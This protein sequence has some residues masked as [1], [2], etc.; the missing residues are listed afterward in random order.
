MDWR[1][2]LRHLAAG[3]NK[4]ETQVWQCKLN[5]S[6]MARE[7]PDLQRAK[8]GEGTVQKTI[9]IHLKM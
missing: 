1:V 2:L 7:Q 6:R 5:I 9:I 8:A 4:F 3:T